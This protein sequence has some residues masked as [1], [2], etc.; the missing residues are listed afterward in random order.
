MSCS[1]IQSPFEEGKAERKTWLEGWIWCWSTAGGRRT[2]AA[3]QLVA[4]SNRQAINGACTGAVA[5]LL[6]FATVVAERW[7]GYGMYIHEG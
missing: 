1:V 7:S 4:D 3:K 5:V 2:G 6:P